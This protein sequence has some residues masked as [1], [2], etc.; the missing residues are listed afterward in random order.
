M[1][2]LFQTCHWTEYT[3]TIIDMFLHFSEC[4]NSKSLWSTVKPYSLI[5]T[6][7]DLLIDKQSFECTPG[8]NKNY[9]HVS[10][11]LTLEC[12]QD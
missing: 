6:D 7:T 5:L 3:Q 10:E 1:D 12:L 9:C 8:I 11:K 2:Y 4:F